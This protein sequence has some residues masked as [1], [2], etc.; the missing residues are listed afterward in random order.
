MRIFDWVRDARFSATL[1][2]GIHFVLNREPRNKRRATDESAQRT[3][4]P[5]EQLESLSQNCHKLEA[6][7]KEKRFKNVSFSMIGNPDGKWSRARENQ[8]VNSQFS[9]VLS[10]WR[11]CTKNILSRVLHFC[12]AKLPKFGLSEKEKAA[13]QKLKISFIWK[14]ERLFSILRKRP[15]SSWLILNPRSF[16]GKARGDPLLE[17][18]EENNEMCS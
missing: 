3:T 8:F 12:C 1:Y 16:I 5:H 13:C 11:K 15:H 9:R 6:S 10:K 2:F 7:T 4:T 14:L 18:S 17:R